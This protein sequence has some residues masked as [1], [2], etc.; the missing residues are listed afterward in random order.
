LKKIVLIALVLAGFVFWYIK[1][2]DPNASV[3]PRYS[4]AYDATIAEVTSLHQEK[5]ILYATV[6][7]GYCK[8]TRAFLES[9]G[10]PYY[11][12]DIEKSDLGRQQYQNLRGSGVPLLIVNS[13]LIRGY[14]TGAIVNALARK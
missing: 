4:A 7:C 11:E 14:S 2:P 3:G 13:Q 8:R 5:V 1:N 12:Y 9:K 6:W 10:I